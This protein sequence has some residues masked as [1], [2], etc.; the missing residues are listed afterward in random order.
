MITV[1]TNPPPAPSGGAFTVIH[2]LQPFASGVVTVVAALCTGLPDMRHIV[3]HGTQLP[4]DAIDRVKARFPA[5]T[6]F[7]PWPSAAREISLKGDLCA[8]R[9]LLGILRPYKDAPRTVV[10]LHSSKAGFLGRLACRILGIRSV[11]YTPH[12][13]AFLRTDIG[14]AKRRFFR[15]LEWVGARMGGMVVGC[16]PSEGAAYAAFGPAVW[17]ANGVPLPPSRPAKG[18]APRMVTFCGLASVQKNPRLFNEIALAFPAQPFCWIGDGPLTRELSAPNIT[19]TGWL[20]PSDLSRILEDTLVF[21]STSSWEGLPC[22]GLEALAAS[23]AL[24]ATDV[25]GNR[26]LVTPG[27]NG[28]LFRGPAE[29]IAALSR[30]LADPEAALRMGRASRALA[31]SRFS[32]E[33]MAAGYRRVYEE[34]AGHGQQVKGSDPDLTLSRGTSYTHLMRIKRRCR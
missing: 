19:I 13:G 3:V 9:E 15:F 29:G 31:E 33:S 20:S 10:H 23:R 12:C 1:M 27:E 16:G 14:P 7:V 21:L 24:L 30:L 6:A 28:F 34:V 32:L 4:V 8:L 25:P 2:V 26:D 18:I 17:V 22:A 5:G 11:I